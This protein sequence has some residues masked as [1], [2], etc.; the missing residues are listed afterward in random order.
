MKFNFL[1]GVGNQHFDVARILWFSSVVS[2][3]G[4]AGAHL[5]INRSFS[6]V[7]FGTGMGLL[8][9]GG[10]AATTAKDIG[11]AKANRTTAETTPAASE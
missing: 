7:E 8:L 3:I 9:A 2:G 1:R 6:P 10:G 5:Y 4:F 11:V